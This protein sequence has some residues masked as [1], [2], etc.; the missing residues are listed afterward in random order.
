MLEARSHGE[1]LA[2]ATAGARTRGSWC[3]ASSW[4]LIILDGASANKKLNGIF[5]GVV[6]YLPMLAITFA[7][8]PIRPLIV[9]K[10]ELQIVQTGWVVK[11]VQS[12]RPAP[13]FEGIF[14][15]DRYGI[16]L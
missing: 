12:K 7:S 4:L 15:V 9:V 3:E 11:I 6:L 14:P 8:T 16:S 10:R 5:V 2:F 1:G 13:H